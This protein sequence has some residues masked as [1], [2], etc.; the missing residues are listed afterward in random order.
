M[1]A[2][3]NQAIDIVLGNVAKYY[4]DKIK[5]HGPNHKGVDWNSP[6]A[7]IIRFEQI[8]K[9]CDFGGNFSITD[10]GCGY[11]ALADYLKAHGCSFEYQGYDISGEMIKK[12]RTVHAGWDKCEF[13]SN[14][15]ELKPTDYL[16]ASGIFNV[17]QDASND[18]W[19]EY[20]LQTLN[21][22]NALGRKGFSFNVLTKYSDPEKM[23]SDLYYA[24]PALLFDY[25]KHKF[26][27]F[28][29]LLHD[30]KLYEFTV[31]VRK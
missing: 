4:D 14:Q 30:Y 28:V 24:D 20:V 26:S 8:L 13:F 9:I 25:C 23:R 27:R 12:A 16:V 3:D 17:K 31:I 21:R 7:Q 11:G 10:Y 29:A 2:K 5:T 1:N 15:S 22:L 19:T 6:E 18:K